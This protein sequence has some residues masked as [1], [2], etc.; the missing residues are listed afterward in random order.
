MEMFPQSVSVPVTETVPKFFKLSVSHSTLLVTFLP[1][2]VT[3]TVSGRL[4]PSDQT[5][6]GS[7]V[8]TVVG[9]S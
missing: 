2:V 9:S 7:S 3:S 1:W 8:L 4:L 6:S 5:T